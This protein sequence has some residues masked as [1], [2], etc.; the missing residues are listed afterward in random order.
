MGMSCS[1]KDTLL[2]E[3][4]NNGYET[5]ISYCSGR[6][7]RE[8]E[9]NGREYNFITNDEF[10]KMIKNDEFIESTSYNALVNGETTLFRYGRKKFSLSPDRKYAIIVNPKGVSAFLKHFG[11]DNCQVLFLDVDYQTRVNRCKNRGDF[12]EREYSRREKAD[13]EDF[14][15]LFKKVTPIKAKNTIDDQVKQCLNLI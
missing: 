6:P 4:L 11:E 9:I 10:V 3:L 2:K 8:G 15:N 14:S 5:I 12:D 13:Q 1:G 7:M